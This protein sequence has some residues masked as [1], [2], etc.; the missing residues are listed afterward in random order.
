MDIESDVCKIDYYEKCDT[1]VQYQNNQINNV[2]SNT[3]E[4]KLLINI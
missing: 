4:F 1:L 3:D 2:I